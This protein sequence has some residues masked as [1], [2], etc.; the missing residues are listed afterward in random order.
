MN[1]NA[2]NIIK[3]LLHIIGTCIFILISG[4]STQKKPAELNYF[5]VNDKGDIVD[6]N[7]NAAYEPHEKEAEELR[8][9]IATDRDTIMIYIHGGL[10]TR[11]DALNRAIRMREAIEEKK[12]IHPIFINWRSGPFTS[13]SEHLFFH[14]KG[15]HWDIAGPL[16]FPFVLLEDL[17]RAIFRSPRTLVNTINTY[18]KTYNFN[19][20]NSGRNAYRLEEMADSSEYYGSLTP[21]NDK[22]SDG[23]IFGDHVTST[24]T[25]GV[26]LL[27]NLLMDFV[28]P[29]AWDVMKRRT[30]LMFVKSRPDKG[31]EYKDISGYSES[32]KG[33][34]NNFLKELKL[35]QDQAENSNKKFVLVGHSMGAFIANNIL[36]A[37]PQIRYDRIIYMGAAC[38]IRDFQMAVIPYLVKNKETEFYN[39]MLDPLAENME[40]FAWGIGGTGSLLVQI[41]DIYERPVA[42]NQ[43]TLGRWENVM[44]GLNYF[45]VTNDGQPYKLLADKDLKKRIHL[46]T[47]PFGKQYPTKHGEFDDIE[48]MNS[49]N[50]YFW[51]ETYH[52]GVTLP[53]GKE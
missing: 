32:R 10:N 41:D 18:S 27:G 1:T 43:R 16:T 45:D 13:Y 33:G 4:C 42:E 21:K 5:F 3:R 25:H 49:V 26:G 15:E 9:I 51:E 19:Y 14:R 6:P 30:E 22:R 34:I 7:T 47:I 50:G 24:L 20:T 48:K 44:N 38:S 12:N 29:G 40:A 35:Y 31:D 28:G 39:Y 46:R 17:G 52:D 37:K 53:S 8:K 36:T 11:D 2:T 23:N